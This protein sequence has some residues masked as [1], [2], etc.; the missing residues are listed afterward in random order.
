MSKTMG[1]T[2]RKIERELENQRDVLEAALSCIEVI[3]GMGGDYLPTNEGIIAVARKII[4]VANKVPG[5]E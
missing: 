4:E 2:G 1:T 5:D 3:D